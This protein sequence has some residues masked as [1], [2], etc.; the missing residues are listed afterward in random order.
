MKIERRDP[1]SSILRLGTL[2]GKVRRFGQSGEMEVRDRGRKHIIRFVNGAISELYLDDEKIKL[3]SLSTVEIQ[4]QIEQF[5]CLPRPHVLFFP[6]PMTASPFDT[7]Q[8]EAIVLKGISSRRDLF[9][10]L[11]L[12]E[13]IPVDTL[14]LDI[15]QRQ[16]FRRL[17]LEK[18]EA[19][20]VE[21][22]DVPTP[23]SMILWKRGLEPSHAGALLVALNLLGAF[24]GHW[25]PGV[26]PRNNVATQL[27]RRVESACFDHELLGVDEDA[28]TEEI[29]RA[30]RG[31]SLGLH[32]DRLIGLPEREI[33]ESRRAFS[34][35]S[36]AH[37][38]LKNSRRSRPVRASGSPIG[39]IQTEK[40]HVPSWSPL[41]S[42]A[43]MA[44]V[45]GELNRAK[46]FAL[47]AL[48][49]SPPDPI[50]IE[51]LKI[52]KKAA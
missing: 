20:L 37:A 19:A 50:R 5:F 40:H 25:Q 3:G 35:A 32:P 36:D 14:C 1:A 44:K 9:N 8:P 41:V 15:S 30:F 46:A 34:C 24:E 28:S 52:I 43:R 18:D 38:R 2:F 42:E 45:R 11:K 39:R 49:L 16:F 33:E 47:K 51:L 29:D 7:V 17:P 21:Q 31:L 6:F 48:A 13:R 10:P 12:I 26:L 4:R 22:L 27:R 23:I